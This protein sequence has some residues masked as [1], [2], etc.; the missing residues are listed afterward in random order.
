MVKNLPV[1]QEMQAQSL[2]WEDSLEKKMATH[3]SI[4]AW[5]IPGWRTLMDS[6]PWGCKRVGY[7]PATK[8]QQH[9]LLIVFFGLPL[10]ISWGRK[11]SD[12]T[13]QLN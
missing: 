4:L 13:E 11:E 8:Q 6:S 7:D 2:G 10:L 3:S 1:N 9:F 5:E 12:T